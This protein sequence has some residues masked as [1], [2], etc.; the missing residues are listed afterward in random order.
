M[1]YLAGCHHISKRGL[2][3][4][5]EAV[6]EVPVALGTVSHLEA[7][8]SEALAVPHAEALEAV[9]AAPVKHAD[10]TGWKQAGQR[11]WCSAR[12]CWRCCRRCGVSW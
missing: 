10:E 8:M 5:A 6:F 2:E 12:T 11:R 4:I 1:A 3:E 9:R 7:P